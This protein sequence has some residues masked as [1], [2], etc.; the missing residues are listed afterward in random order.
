MK[1]SKIK[2]VSDKNV[3]TWDSPNGMFYKFKYTFE[4]GESL[5][6]QHKTDAPKFRVGEEVEYE[7]KRTH[8]HYGNSG[9]VSKPNSFGGGKPRKKSIKDIR[10]MCKTNAVDAIYAV[11]AAYSQERIPSSDAG[12]LIGFT[13][14]GITEDIDMWGDEES[15]L[16]SRLASV[17]TAAKGAGFLEY[18]SV[19]DL[20]QRA[21]GIYGY[22]IKD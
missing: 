17:N 13:L 6:A 19:N 5:T 7:I 8:E 10:G 20:V 22:I 9:K 14:G 18:N 12:V 1:T 16:I 4:D 15:L 3:G 21:K 11:N 2:S